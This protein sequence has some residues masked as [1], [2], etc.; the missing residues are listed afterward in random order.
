MNKDEQKQSKVLEK[1]SS[2]PDRTIA[3]GA[4]AIEFGTSECYNK[5]ICISLHMPNKDLELNS[6]IA[7]QIIIKAE[8]LLG[9]SK[10][11]I[12]TSIFSVHTLYL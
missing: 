11:T 10:V 4:S 3:F 5:F 1:I 8:L 9:R 2:L 12:L 6:H 7:R